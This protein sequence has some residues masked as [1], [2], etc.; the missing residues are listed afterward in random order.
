M[1]IQNIINSAQSIEVSRPALVATSMSRSGRLLTGTR[2]WAKPWRFIV[3]A[4]PMWRI[5]DVRS[6]IEDVMSSDK[7]TEVTIQLG[8]GSANWISAYQGQVGTTSGVLNGITV[9]AVT[10][11]QISLAYTGLTAG[12]VIVRAGDII[13]PT[14]HRYPYVAT[15]DVTATGATGTAVINMNRGFLPQTGYSVVGATVRVG[16]ACSWQVKVSNLPSY[17]YL[18]GQFVEFTGDF[19]LIESIL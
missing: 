13:Q 18:P 2:N 17:K 5:S 1:S 9:S 11:T 12:Q 6:V 15:S 8:Q 7:H 14:G 16:T 19:E 10:G 3:S 4:K